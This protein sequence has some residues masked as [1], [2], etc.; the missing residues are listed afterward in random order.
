MNVVALLVAGIIPMIV[1]FIY[2]H[3]KVVGS[4]W[5][6]V[7]GMTEEKARQGNMIVIFGVSYLLSVMLA[8]ILST[9]VIHQNGLA[10]LFAE[11][12]ANELFKQVAEAT[13]DKYRTFKHGALHGF[14]TGVFLAFPILGTNALYEQKGWKY[15]FINVGYWVIT[16]TLM[17]GLLCAWQ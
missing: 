17:G 3:K 12:S 16:L 15:I 8:S 10:S 1:G 13:K 11:D 9:I 5:M 2:Y 4:A 6:S 7:T 14:I